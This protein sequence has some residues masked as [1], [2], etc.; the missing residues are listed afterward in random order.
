MT[1]VWRCRLILS[2][3]SAAGLC[4]KYFRLSL[5]RRARQGLRHR[6]SRL[7]QGNHRPPENRPHDPRPDSCINFDQLATELCA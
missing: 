1:V 3:T 6:A 5:T 7:E 2:A 4:T